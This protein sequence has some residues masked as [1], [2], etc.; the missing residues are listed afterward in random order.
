MVY[1]LWTK[2]KA[3]DLK[4]VRSMRLDASEPEVLCWS[5]REVLESCSIGIPAK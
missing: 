1:R 3:K 4:V 5:P 2:K